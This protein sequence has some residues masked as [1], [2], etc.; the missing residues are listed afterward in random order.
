M[1]SWQEQDL[2]YIRACMQTDVPQLQFARI[3]PSIEQLEE[4]SELLKKA[5]DGLE[6]TRLAKL[7]Q[8]FVAASQMD[9]GRFQ[10]SDH[11]Q[12]SLISNWLHSIPLSLRDRYK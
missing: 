11:S 12:T 5:A 2:A 7:M 6:V 1:T 10:L 9:A 8:R 4:F 3:F